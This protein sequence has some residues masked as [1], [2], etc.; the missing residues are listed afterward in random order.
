MF[1]YVKVNYVNNNFDMLYNINLQNIKQFN[2]VVSFGLTN[3]LIIENTPL[4]K[5]YMEIRNII[6]NL[7]ESF[8]VSFMFAVIKNK[9]DLYDFLIN[10]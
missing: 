2:Y 5:R 10:S 6:N 1:E 7:D 8:Y 9:N 4:L 3:Y